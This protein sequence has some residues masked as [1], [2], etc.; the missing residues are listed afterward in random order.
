MNTTVT[1]K[2]YPQFVTSAAGQG[3]TATCP[4]GFS[5]FRFAPAVHNRPAAITAVEREE[6]GI[7]LTLTTCAR[8]APL[9]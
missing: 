2:E 1:Q 3:E 9:S 5:G 7:C 8:T 4:G 6:Q